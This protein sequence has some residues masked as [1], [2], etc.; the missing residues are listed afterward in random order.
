MFHKSIF[1]VNQKNWAVINQEKP[2]PNRFYQEWDWHPILLFVICV[3]IFGFSIHIVNIIYKNHLFSGETETTTGVV[4]NKK[5]SKSKD[6]GVVRYYL[7]YTYSVNNIEYQ[8][9]QPIWKKEYDRLEIGSEVSII[10][11]P[12]M[13]HESRPLEYYDSFAYG[14]D[15]LI[16]FGFLIGLPL[17]AYR[18][19]I[20]YLQNQEL[21]KTGQIIMGQLNQI[22]VQNGKYAFTK[23][24]VSFTAPDTN[25]VISEKREYLLGQP[26]DNIPNRVV[27]VYIFYASEDSWEVL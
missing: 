18:P 4:T 27:P 19:F 10:Y 11:L 17:I 12:Q 5:I 14:H 16:A 1:L 8:S 20:R 15:L 22:H 13:P 9:K 26:E 2:Y 3:A 21:K 7:D 6:G 24:D 23:V 25:K